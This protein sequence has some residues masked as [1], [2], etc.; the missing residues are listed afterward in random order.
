MKKQQQM[1]T[2]NLNDKDSVFI[3]DGKKALAYF[4]RN[5]PVKVDNQLIRELTTMSNKIAPKNLRLCLHSSPDAL[6]H[7]MII[8]E[9]HDKYYRPHKHL[10][11]GETFHILEGD[12]GVFSFDDLGNILDACVLNAKD[13]IIYKVAVDTYHAVMPLSPLVIYHESKP[14]PFAGEGESVFPTWAPDGNDIDETEEYIRRL[15]KYMSA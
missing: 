8:F 5:Q 7:D 9:R 10:T 11:K 14:G 3:D 15:K 4:C 1:S 2:V 6:F 13:N 12:M